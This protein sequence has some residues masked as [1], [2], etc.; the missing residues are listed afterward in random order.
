MAEAAAPAAAGPS[1][2]AAGPAP[3][4]PHLLELAVDEIALSGPL[5]VSPDRLWALLATRTAEAGAGGPDALA[6]PGLRSRLWQGLQRRS[7]DILFCLRE[8]PEAAGRVAAAAARVPPLRSAAAA[9][10]LRCAAP[11]A[12]ARPIARAPPM[13]ANR[14]PL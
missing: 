4:L 13:A 11:P 10:A 5:G 12:H 3:S 8:E 1:A 2:A 14:T 9:V 6:A 7:A